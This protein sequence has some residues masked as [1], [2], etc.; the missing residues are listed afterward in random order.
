MKFM[1]TSQLKR[2]AAFPGTGSI[3]PR[4]CWRRRIGALDPFLKC[5]RR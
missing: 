2:C 1:K 4:A 3:G 5:K